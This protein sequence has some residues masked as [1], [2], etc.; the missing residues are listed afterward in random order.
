MSAAAAA[1]AGAP[2]G[3]A[4]SDADPRG[5]QHADVVVAVADREHALG[6]EILDVPSFLMGMVI[7]R[8]EIS[9]GSEDPPTPGRRGR[10]CRRSGHEL[11][12]L[13][14]LLD[15]LA[16]AGKKPAILGKRPGEV[17]DAVDDAQVAVP[18]D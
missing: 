14:E 15:A 3:Q 17:R 2:L 18:G 4:D 5:P 6:A 1:S 12:V 8:R 10:G 13:G 11:H 16:H 7:A 9:R